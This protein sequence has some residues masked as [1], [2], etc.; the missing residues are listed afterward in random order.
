MDIIKVLI[1]YIYIMI[2]CL[3]LNLRIE[4][5]LRRIQKSNLGITI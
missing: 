2:S 1:D 5:A 4:L 3:R